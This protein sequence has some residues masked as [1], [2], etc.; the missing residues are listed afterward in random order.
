MEKLIP[1]LKKKIELEVALK[2]ILYDHDNLAIKLFRQSS[3]EKLIDKTTDKIFKVL[4]SNLIYKPEK[5]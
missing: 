4:S 1:K 3:R 2:M 5:I